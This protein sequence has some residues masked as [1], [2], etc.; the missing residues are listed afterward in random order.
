MSTEL[1]PEERALA[2]IAE[3]APVDAVEMRP[4]PTSGVGR[5]FAGEV[6]LPQLAEVALQDPQFDPISP[7]DALAPVQRWLGEQGI[8]LLDLGA[9]L[10]SDTEEVL[11]EHARL[12]DTRREPALVRL[13]VGDERYVVRLDAGATTVF[14]APLDAGI[15]LGEVPHPPEAEVGTPDLGVLLGTRTPPEW[16]VQAFGELASSSRP[17]DRVMAAGLALRGWGP[18]TTEERAAET[19]RMIR[20]EPGIAARARDWMNGVSER[21]RGLLVAVAIRDAHHLI[22]TAEAVARLWA[23][24][25]SQAQTVAAGVLIGRDELESVL[26]ALRTVG[27]ADELEDCLEATDLELQAHLTALLHQPGAPAAALGVERRSA[28][29]RRELLPRWWLAAS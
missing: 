21:D 2:G 18:E 16:L 24:S 5:A 4:A 23:T 12:I 7:V 1:T 9:D 29:A 20:G 27:A 28:L 8:F 10:V 25:A 14:R 13:D 17:L 6:A 15:M 26:A 19:Q 3:D 22:E 11:F